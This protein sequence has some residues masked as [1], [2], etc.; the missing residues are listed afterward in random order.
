MCDQKKIKLYLRMN[1]SEKRY[2]HSIRTAETAEKLCILHGCN[3]EKGFIAGLI[4]DIAREIN[5]E[6]LQKITKD[7]G[8]TIS[9][10]E[11]EFPVLLHGRVG[12]IIAKKELLIDDEEILEAVRWHTTGKPGMQ[13]LTSILFV[14]DYIE[15]GREHITNIFRQ[16][17]KNRKLDEIVLLTVKESISYCRKKGYSVAEQTLLLYHELEKKVETN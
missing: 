4:H 1:L 14:A 6:G 5:N 2:L 7:N 8:Y 3:S 13:G 17:L 16:S 10:V 9:S 15:P 12:A 11:K